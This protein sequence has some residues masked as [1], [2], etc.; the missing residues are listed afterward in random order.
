[1]LDITERKR[2]EEKLA[3]AQAQLAR[4][5][6]VTLLGELN[7]SIAHEVNQARTLQRFG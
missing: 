6:R 5:A 1:M 3:E 7:A 4:M 2:A